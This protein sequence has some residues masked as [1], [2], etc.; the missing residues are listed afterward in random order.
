M[1]EISAGACQ[2][3]QIEKVI[4]PESVE[5][6]DVGA[7]KD[8]GITEIHIS[9]KVEKGMLAKNAL[10]GNGTGKKGKGLSITV[11][12]KKDQKALKKQLK[13]AG[14]PKAKVKVAK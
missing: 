3:Q 5:K 12:S 10:A 9:G 7:F 11:E 8:C 4:I 2:G 1:T 6:I 13:K 14:A